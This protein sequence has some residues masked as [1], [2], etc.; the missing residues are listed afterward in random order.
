MEFIEI[1]FG[2]IW[3]HRRKFIVVFFV[4]FLFQLHYA[5][6]YDG[7]SVVENNDV[8]SDLVV[9]EISKKEEV[10]DSKEDTIEQ[11][12]DIYYVDVKGE[13]KNPGV[14]K[15][16]KGKRVFDAI[17]LAGG[18]LKDGDTSLINLSMKVIDEMVIYVRNKKEVDLCN[19]IILNDAEISSDSS[20]KVESKKININTADKTTLLS[21]P[22]IGSVKAEAI[23]EYR[24]KN[25]NFKKIEDIKNVSGIGDAVFQEI[26][27]Y[28]T[29]Q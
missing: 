11:I 16:E 9:E 20:D 25:G 15:I 13:V 23:I 2:S 21:I 7:V 8:S 27:D 4:L 17:K 12:D 18:V 6:A 26:K 14:Y 10:L 5:Y 24:N 1:I 29:V 3:E 19:D 28:I 22:S